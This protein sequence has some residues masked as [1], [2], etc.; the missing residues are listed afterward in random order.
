MECDVD[1]N[2]CKKIHSDIK[3][4][5]LRMYGMQKRLGTIARKNEEG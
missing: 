4:K 3:Q 2:V 5:V 1:D